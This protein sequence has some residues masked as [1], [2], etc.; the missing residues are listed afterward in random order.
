MSAKQAGKGVWL[1]LRIHGVHGTPPHSMLGVAA[2]KVGQ[3][4]GDGITGIWRTEDGKV[5][6]RDLNRAPRLPVAIR[7]PFAVVEAY[8]WGGL[9]SNVKGVLSWVTRVLWMFLLPFALMNLAYWARPELS[10][11]EKRVPRPSSTP[12]GSREGQPG[13]RNYESTVTHTRTL[14]GPSGARRRPW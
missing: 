14:P 6:L 4:A 8:S 10:Y 1:E 7:Q 9:T 11:R 13:A 12:R 5:P 3:V 2:N